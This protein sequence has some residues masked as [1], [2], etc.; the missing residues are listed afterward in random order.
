MYCADKV[1][2]IVPAICFYSNYFAGEI[3]SA[4][5]SKS[6]CIGS[7]PEFNYCAQN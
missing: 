7:K 5:N 3:Q 1:A 2:P 6:L 4:W